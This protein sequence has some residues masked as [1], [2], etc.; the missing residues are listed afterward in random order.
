MSHQTREALRYCLRPEKP[1]DRKRKVKF[2]SS[3]VYQAM[4]GELKLSIVEAALVLGVDERTS[5][6]WFTGEI[7]LPRPVE[8]FLWYMI[9]TKVTPE[10][11]L[12]LLRSTQSRTWLPKKRVRVRRKVYGN[13][14]SQIVGIEPSPKLMEMAR[15]ASRRTSMQL[16]LIEGTAEAIPI[17]DRSIDTV[18]TTW[19]MCSIPAVEP[20]LRTRATI[21]ATILVSV[22]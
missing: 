16:D 7:D 14:V 17:D 20:A 19:T 22:E 18:V 12:T 11:V 2:V 15:K 1:E 21:T 8:R 5:R 10:D 6:R 13:S 4:L 9:A 3:F